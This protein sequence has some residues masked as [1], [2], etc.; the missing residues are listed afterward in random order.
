[1]TFRLSHVAYAGQ[2]PQWTEPFP[3]IIHQ[4]WKTNTLTMYQQEFRQTVMNHYPGYEFRLWT[5]D[6]LAPFVQAEFPTYFEMWSNLSPFIK[7][8]DCIRYMWLYKFGGIYC[9]MDITIYKSLHTLFT[10][11]QGAA[12]IPASHTEATW[13]YDA[14][15]HVSE[16]AF[17]AAYPKHP[18]F[19][20]MLE[21][22]KR[23]ANRCT[24][25]AT[26]PKAMSNVLLQRH[27]QNGAGRIWNRPV[28]FLSLQQLGLEGSLRYIPGVAHVSYHVQ[29][30]TWS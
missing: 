27:D 11:Y 16:P 10:Q 24:L 17:M 20:A 13:R 1:M 15:P 5:D 18:F 4:T 30:N 23:N 26:G 2:E 21:Y 25:G 28:V 12:F 29:T 6:Q 14:V 3:Q 19:L 7:K 22:I 8:I 9:D